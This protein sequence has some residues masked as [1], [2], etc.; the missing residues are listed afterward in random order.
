M[1][2]YSQ[3]LR[4]LDRFLGAYPYG[5]W[6]KWISLTNK[7]SQD[8]LSRLEPISGKI[9]SVTELLPNDATNHQQENEA[10]ARCKTAEE[11]EQNLVK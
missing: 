11:R 8:T 1:E 9:Q 4:N 10:F 7:I 2:R 3:N 5:H 6:K